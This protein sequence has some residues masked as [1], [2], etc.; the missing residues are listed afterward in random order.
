MIRGRR[1]L[2]PTGSAALVALLALAACGDTSL[3]PPPVQTRVDVDTPA[4]R[5]Q[6]RAAGIEPCPRVEGAG[7]LPQRE[8]ACLGGG[9][10]VD[11]SQVGGP[12]VVPLWA[13]WCVRCRKELPIYQ[14]LAERAGGRL[15]VLGVDYQDTQPDVAIDLLRRAG[16]TFPSVADPGGV[17]AETYRIRGLP[18]VAWVGKDGSVVLDNP[19]ID[20]YADLVTLVSDRLG[21]RLPPAAAG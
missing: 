11:L 19:K 6:K 3:T 16:A 2:V 14:Q 18:A 7:D 13:S 8:L 12:A 17:L 10:A 21:V 5:A 4:L 15:T 20:T 1:R 9:R